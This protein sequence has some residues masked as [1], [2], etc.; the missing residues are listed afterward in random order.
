[1]LYVEKDC[2]NEIDLYTYAFTK[3]VKLE[4]EAKLKEFDFKLLHG[5]LPCNRNLKK[6]KLRWD[7]KCDVCSLS[8]SIEHLL[9]E[10]KYVKPHGD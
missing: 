10:C 4:K 9:L 6:W 7:D 2:D 5:I 3:I 1:M 8:Q